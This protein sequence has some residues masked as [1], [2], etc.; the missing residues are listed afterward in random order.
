MTKHRGLGLA[1]AARPGF[2]LIELLVV[3][4][5]IAV[6]IGLL[7]PAVQKAREAAARNTCANNLRQ[8]GLGI[9]HYYDQNKHYL[10]AGEGT[11]FYLESQS[12]TNNAV[13]HGF[14]ANVSATATVTPEY[15]FAAKDGLA[16]PG[17]GLEPPG[18]NGTAKT[19]F[20][21]N[22]VDTGG[23]NGQAIGGIPSGV[24]LGLQ[25]F[26]SQSVFTRILPFMEKDDLYVGYSLNYPYNDT[27]A[28]QNQAAAQTAI[29]TFLC[30]SNPL[31]PANGLDN[32]GY[33]YTDYGP[34]VY[35][36]ID[37]VTGVRNKNT[38]M[39][40]ALHGTLDGKGT[41]LADISDGLS[42]TIAIAED[43]GR[44]DAMPGAYVDPLFGLANA[45]NGTGQARS[46]WRWAEPDNG[47]GVSGD[48]LA[49][50]NFGG[51]NAAYPGLINGAGTATGIGRARVVNNN[52]YPFGG[53]AATCIW[54]NVTNCGP[55]DEV[56]SFH[57][58]GANVLFMDGHV[59]FLS[60]N[61]DAI[62]MR[63]LVTAGEHIE[64]NVSS[65]PAP[66]LNTTDY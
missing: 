2:T 8:M 23:I 62:V 51:V 58:T 33:G 21:P 27:T 44:F 34:T 66:I 10:D 32:N 63:R 64:P 40:G 18:P 14:A 56:F 24:T 15:S 31:R 13:G 38:R 55:N 37:P 42:S 61:T 17:P 9:H 20:F 65:G 49:G 5:I 22:G 50:N 19:W 30:P 6:L 28:P 26:T 25:P 52:R 3:I 47:Y 11:L 45:A 36:D 4:A 7:I 46:F 48:P 16:P 35:T 39:H 43:V 41:T 60:E 54:T 57:G 29:P 12:N 53:S 59:N 1:R